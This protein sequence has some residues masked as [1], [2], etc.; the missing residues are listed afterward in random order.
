MGPETHTGRKKHAQDPCIKLQYDTI[1]KLQIAPKNC[2]LSLA[3]K[4]NEKL[5]N[6]NVMG[7]IHQET[8]YDKV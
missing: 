4:N 2:Q 7:L 1:Q 6:T 5:K 8:K 3:H